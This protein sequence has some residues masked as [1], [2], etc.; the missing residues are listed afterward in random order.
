MVKGTREVEDFTFPTENGLQ[1]HLIDTPGF[2]DTNKSDT[3]ILRDIGDWLA[4]SYRAGTRLSGILFLHSISSPRLNGATRRNLDMFKR[5]CGKDCF[6]SVVLATTFWDTVDEKTGER[7]EQELQKIDNFWGEM[8]K[9][10]SH[11]MRH[12]QNAVSANKILDYMIS[13]RAPFTV[14]IQLELVEQD[15]NLIDTAAGQALGSDLRELEQQH[16]RQLNNLRKDYE[17]AKSQQNEI[18]AQ[19]LRSEQEKL[20]AEIRS[21]HAAAERLKVS[22]SNL[23]LEKKE[24]IRKTQEEHKA[25][26]VEMNKMIKLQQEQKESLDHA[27]VENEK[28]KEELKALQNNLVAAQRKKDCHKSNQGRYMSLNPD[29][30]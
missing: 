22:R 8:R 21:E 24:Q 9:A 5:L 17:A 23:E 13:N 2:D 11:Y 14:A 15:K 1:V 6:K 19:R 10:G 4:T 16:V 25:Q 30:H 20:Q 26:I 7:R 27:K 3:E 29:V 28:L 18:A 12:D